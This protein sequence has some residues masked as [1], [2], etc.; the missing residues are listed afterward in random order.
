M[1]KLLFT[2]AAFCLLT[3]GIN[4]QSA[5]CDITGFRTQTIGGWGAAPSGDNPGSYLQAN[6]DNAF[7]DGLTIGCDAT[8]VS[9][10][11]W[12]AVNDYLPAGGTPD[13]LKKSY[14]NPKPAQLKNTLVSQVIALTLSLGFDIADPNYSSSTTNLGDLMIA[15]GEFMGMTVNQVLAMA[16]DALCGDGD[17][18]ALN[19]AVTSINENFVDG[20][21]FGTFLNCPFRR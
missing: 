12:K 19:A 7:P 9:F 14:T 13:V 16:N 3:F 2:V 11:S 8:S 5:D 15:E 10:T 18:D 17:V 6:F 20:T 21:Y 4:A 1:K